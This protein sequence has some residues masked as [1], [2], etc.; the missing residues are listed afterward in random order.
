MCRDPIRQNLVEL[1]NNGQQRQI[2]DQ[3]ELEK[4]HDEKLEKKEK[5]KD[6]KFSKRIQKQFRKQI[7]K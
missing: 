6:E 5:L 4:I 2:D 1:I 3:R 7:N